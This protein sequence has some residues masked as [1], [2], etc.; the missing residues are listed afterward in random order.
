MLLWIFFAG[1]L[2]SPI[3]TKP[4]PEFPFSP[5]CVSSLVLQLDDLEPEKPG[6]L[7]IPINTS[8][9]SLFLNMRQRL[10]IS[11]LSC[12]IQYESHAFS[13]RT[14]LHMNNGDRMEQGRIMPNNVAST[15]A[16]PYGKFERLS[17]SFSFVFDLYEAVFFFK[18]L[19]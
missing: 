17:S 16:P 9:A 18:D 10:L 1:N 12:I 15:T 6:K 5:S 7:Y 2:T 13:C 3:F 8:Y 4:P 11:L 14:Q 19:K